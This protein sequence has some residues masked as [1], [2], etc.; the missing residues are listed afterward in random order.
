MR[1]MHIQPDTL[2]VRSG[3]V[4]T[5]NDHVP[6]LEIICPQRSKY[7]RKGPITSEYLFAYATLQEYRD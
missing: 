1:L 4:P 6:R 5:G 2:P 3:A 7:G